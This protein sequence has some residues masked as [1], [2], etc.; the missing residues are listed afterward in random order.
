MWI[1]SHVQRT[2]SPA[3]SVKAIGNSVPSYPYRRGSPLL[4]GVRSKYKL[5]T[6]QIPVLYRTRNIEN[7]KNICK[8]R[9]KRLDSL[10]CLHAVGDNAVEFFFASD[11][12]A[13]IEHTNRVIF[14]EDD[15]IAAVA[16][17]KLYS[18]GQAFG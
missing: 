8:T 1:P 18:P 4:I 13:I 15:D 16:D 3:Q 12:S 14:L 6:E 2:P 11:A 5:S 17:G 9:M 7:V 10:T